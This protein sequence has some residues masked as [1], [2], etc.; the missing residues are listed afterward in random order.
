VKI[1]VRQFGVSMMAVV[2]LLTLSSCSLRVKVKEEWGNLHL[3][4]IPLGEVA[5]TWEDLQRG[6]TPEAEALDRYNEA[7]RSSLVQVAENWTKGGGEVS[8]LET[9]GGGANLRINLANVPDLAGADEIVP[10]DFVKVRRGLRSESVVDGV[11]TPLIVRKSRSETDPM[12]PET[13]LWVPVTAILNLD[14]PTAPLLEFIDP[15]V[16]GSIAYG[17]KEFPLSANYT[18]AFARDFQ[19]RQFQFESLGAL[20]R[21]EE[22]ADRMGI[23]RVTPFHPDKEPVVFIHGINSSPSTWD[24]MMNRLY[25]DEAIRERYEFWTFGYPTGAPIPYMAAEFR[26]AVGKM[27][28]FRAGRGARDQAIT[29]VG[30]SMGGL[31]GKTMT[32]SSGDA[33]WNRLFKV[34]LPQL[35]IAEAERETL[36][37]MLYFES[38]PE[39]ERVVFCASPHKGTQIVEHP[40]AKLVGGLIQVPTQLL[41][42][43]TEIIT[44]SADAMTPEGIE[45]TRDRLTSLE[46]LSA[47]AWTTSV[48]LNK[49]LNPGV[50]YHSIIGNS[51]LPRVPL[52]KTGDGVVPYTSAHIEGVASDLVVRP[53]GHSV[54]HTDA[55]VEEIRRILNLP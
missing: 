46:Q 19:D 33:E 5:G 39:V 37:R 15:T 40:G 8:L 27:L 12:I 34:P 14:Q 32:F 50:T 4:P 31:I 25:G 38:I 41:L 21:F 44:R 2:M 10:A 11:G 20:L 18:A 51:R 7:V 55:A 47:N 42:L 23:Y 28:A 29:I 53:S 17:G 54:H 49:P 30:H 48:F 22:Y 13:G 24:E 1:R 6:L 52:E 35:E 9:T 45:F 36:R 16:R 3:Q 43:S 26:E